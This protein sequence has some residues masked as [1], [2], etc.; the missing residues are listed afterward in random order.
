[1]FAECQGLEGWA[2]KRCE[3][4]TGYACKLRRVLIYE[5]SLHGALES[6]CETARAVWCAC[7]Y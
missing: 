3:W 1:V 6:T 7:M 4:M 5:T 2:T